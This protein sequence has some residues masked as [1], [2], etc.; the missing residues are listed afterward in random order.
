MDESVLKII[1]EENTGPE[2]VAVLEQLTEPK[3]DEQIASELGVKS[4][5]IRKLLNDLHGTSLVSYKRTKDK[6]TGWY[7]YVW[8]KRDDKITEYGQIKLDESLSKLKIRL[9]YERQNLFVCSC[10]TSVTMTQAMDLN[11][12]CPR[13]NE[14]LRSLDNSNRIRELGDKIARIEKII[15]QV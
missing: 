15:E 12:I 5:I 7:S 2:H 10:D 14:R 3:H 4:T 11:F 13:C 9:E 6:S 1:L 8:E